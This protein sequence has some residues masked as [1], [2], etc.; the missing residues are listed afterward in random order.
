[1]AQITAAMVKDLR[2]MTGSGMMECKK[3]LVEA[4]GDMPRPSPRPSRSCSPPRWVRRPL[5]PS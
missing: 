5:R 2:E 1:M 3:A 4:E